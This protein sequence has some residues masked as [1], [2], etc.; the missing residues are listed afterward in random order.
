MLSTSSIVVRQR[1]H[2]RGLPPR[3][4][5]DRSDIIHAPGARALDLAPPPPVAT[6]DARVGFG[7]CC[8]SPGTAIILLAKLVCERRSAMNG[9]SDQSGDPKPVI[10]PGSGAEE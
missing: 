1:G 4:L 3:L 7:A 10:E 8:A 2:G 5:L 9:T 6:R